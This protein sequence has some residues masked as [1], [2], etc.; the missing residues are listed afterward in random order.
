MIKWLFI[1]RPAGFPLDRAAGRL[2]FG[3]AAMLAVA[4]QVLAQDGSLALP[5][6]NRALFEP[7]GAERF[8]VGT[9]GKPWS[10]GTFG[11]VRSEGGQLHEGL[12]IRAISRDR[13]GEPLDPVVATAAA[14]VVYVNT[15]PSLSNYGNYV[16]LRHSLD[17]LDVYSLYAHLAEVRPGLKV[18]QTLSRGEKIGTMGRTSNTGQ[19]ISK[20]RAHLHFE[21][22]LMLNERFAQWHRQARPGERNDHG[23]YNGRNFL[24]LDP[25][26]IFLSQAAQ[27]THFSLRQFIQGRAELCR[28]ALRVKDFQ[29]ARRYAPLLLR[30]PAAEKEGVA[31]YEIALDYVGIPFQIIPRPESQLRSPARVTLLSVNEAEQRS[32]PCRNLVRRRQGRWELGP[33]GEQ[34]V[35]LLIY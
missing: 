34:L 2:A 20:E 32:H 27:G 4:L 24:G 17:G 15:R 5:T 23:N 33:Q 25:A 18:G 6:P 19:A 31:G 14:T 9:V 29:W 8:F 12:D 3:V 30:N 16:I 7:G 21:L 10:S 11:C 35:D 22:N 1:T 28:I 26:A 13:R